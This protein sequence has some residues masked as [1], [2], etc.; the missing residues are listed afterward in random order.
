MRA[1]ARVQQRLQSVVPS[2]KPFK[3]VHTT[4]Y[5]VH[6][7]IATRYVVARVF[8]AGDAAHINNPLGG[9]GMNG[10]IHDAYNL[11][12]KLVQV[13]TGETGDDLLDRYE[14]ERRPVALEYI[15][16]HTIRNKRNLETDD[17][18]EQAAFRRELHETLAD[19]AKTRVYLKRVSMIASLEQAAGVE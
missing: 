11:A 13:M 4:A 5:R 18:A 15:N 16:K 7:R 8:L 3:V 14:K 12:G 19:P 6:E 2:L 10:G 1:P 9:M 17:P